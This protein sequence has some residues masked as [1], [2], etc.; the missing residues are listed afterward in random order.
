MY[1]EIYREREMLICQYSLS[2]MYIHVYIYIYIR[3]YIYIY[4]HVIIKSA[5][6]ELGDGTTGDR[7]IGNGYLH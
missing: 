3:L 7:R 4:T 6:Q 1:R 5:P 2:Y